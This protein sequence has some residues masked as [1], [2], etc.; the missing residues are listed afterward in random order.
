MGEELRTCP[1]CG[2]GATFEHLE[3][4]RWSI[5]CED[6]ECIGFVST[7]TFARRAEAIAAWNTRS[8]QPTEGVREGMVERIKRIIRC[9]AAD[10]DRGTGEVFDLVDQLAALSPSIERDAGYVMVPRVPTEAMIRA[11]IEAQERER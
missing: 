4:G 2:G 1:F 10:A 11:L 9:I 3:N 8:P 6:D 5:G 7:T